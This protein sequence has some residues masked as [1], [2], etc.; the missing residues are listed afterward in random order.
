[1]LEAVFKSAFVQAAKGDH[2]S[3][4][5]VLEMA[6]LNEKVQQQL[7][8]EDDLENKTVVLWGRNA[9]E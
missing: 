7:E 1:M 8:R 5:L 4:K 3:Q 9:D 6:R 2:R